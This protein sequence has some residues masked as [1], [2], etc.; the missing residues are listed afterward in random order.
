[1]RR[2]GAGVAAAVVAGLLVLSVAA[3]EPA[4]AI[5]AGMQ[6]GVWFPAPSS[7]TTETGLV[8]W[9]FGNNGNGWAAQ[10]NQTAP[11]WL[12]P[13]YLRV[14]NSNF[15][16]SP[17]WP[18]T[19]GDVV[20][21]EV[22]SY[23]WQGAGFAKLDVVGFAYDTGAPLPW[24]G[25]SVVGYVGKSAT[26]DAGNRY[27]VWTGMAT[28]DWAVPA[29]VTC[30]RVRYYGGASLDW[31]Q[32]VGTITSQDEGDCIGEVPPGYDADETLIGD[33][34]TLGFQYAG[35][36]GKWGNAWARVDSS[37]LGET[38]AC[39]VTDH[40]TVEWR[41]TSGITAGD[42]FSFS[43]IVRG[44]TA[45]SSVAAWWIVSGANGWAHYYGGA[46]MRGTGAPGEDWDAGAW[47]TA[48]NPNG[49]AAAPVGTVG[50]AFEMGP[51]TATELI[52]V[53]DVTGGNLDETGVGPGYD[54][55]II[56]EDQSVGCA[57]PSSILDLAGLGSYIGCSLA[58]VPGAMANAFGGLLSGLFIPSQGWMSSQVDTFM[59]AARTHAP[60]VW[61]DE[62]LTALGTFGQAG[63]DLNTG[64]N[65]FG[66]SVSLPIGAFASTVAPFRPLA[67]GAVWFMAALGVW[68][69]IRGSVGG[70]SE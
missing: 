63:G 28:T 7:A 69:A 39:V 70:S 19:P 41:P 31:A 38:G 45:Q 1:M 65:L 32:L 29:G 5:S 55:T 11:T 64:V 42:R 26:Y 56:G 59:A 57:G 62:A 33:M 12:S 27:N 50:I 60:F 44:V 49:I 61:A 24:D 47:S 37:I 46:I 18:V 22:Y 21:G 54:D 30:V 48:T 16:Y 66:V 20:R 36:T 52:S 6:V 25:E 2:R 8:S 43:W 68:G 3:V 10:Q 23:P 4:A 17:C 34:P 67:A 51:G 14:P 40:A 53:H 15:A 9:Q 13:G 58:K 35:F